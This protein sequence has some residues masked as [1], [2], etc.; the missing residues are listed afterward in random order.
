MMLDHVLIELGNRTPAQAIEDGVEPRR[1][2]E[3][4]CKDFDVPRA[5]W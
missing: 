5:R 3:G 4:L 1:V 2:W